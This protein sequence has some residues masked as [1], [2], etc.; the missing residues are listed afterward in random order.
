VTDWG[1]TLLDGSAGGVVGALGAFWSAVWVVKR[2]AR[3][4]HR[5]RAIQ[6]VFALEDCLSTNLHPV[7]V[8]M[9]S[10][11]KTKVMLALQQ[12]IVEL[13]AVS[14]RYSAPLRESLILITDA[15]I[16]EQSD[17][18]IEQLQAAFLGTHAAAAGVLRTLTAE[19]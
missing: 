6:A 11:A 16:D 1:Q 12:A 17:A 4:D 19:D 10:Q 3:A 14:S 18:P 13:T 15:R 5:Q 8:A 2:Q 7:D 9:A